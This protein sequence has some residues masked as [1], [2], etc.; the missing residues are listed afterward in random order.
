MRKAVHKLLRIRRH[1]E[2]RGKKRVSF[3]DE[4]IGGP[5]SFPESEDAPDQG[6]ED[7]SLCSSN[8]SSDHEHD[9]EVESENGDIKTL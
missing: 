1:R 4:L 9:H 5:S 7:S 3:N 6:G 2:K 8:S